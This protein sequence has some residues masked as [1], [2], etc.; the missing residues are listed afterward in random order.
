MSD[1]DDACDSVRAPDLPT[2]FGC[3]SIT[4]RKPFSNAWQLGAVHRSRGNQGPEGARPAQPSP[5]AA[6]VP[7][8]SPSRRGRRTAPPPY[9]ADTMKHVAAYL[10]A[11]LGGNSSPDAK[12]RLHSALDLP[13][14][15]KPPRRTVPVPCGVPLA[16]P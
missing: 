6:A 16:P 13:D 3:A 11:Q 5:Q 12:V 15:Q 14:A 1:R 4:P 10:L 7:G 2:D 9:C 8:C